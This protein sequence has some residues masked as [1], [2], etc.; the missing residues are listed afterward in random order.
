METQEAGN[1]KFEIPDKVT[2]SDLVE[3]YV[4]VT[5]KNNNPAVELRKLT[6]DLELVKKLVSAAYHERPIILLPRFSNKI[7]ALN[8]L[9]QK[10]I[11]FFDYDENIFYFTL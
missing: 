8:S 4:Q 11:I 6:T 7:Q 9:Q 10:G 2:I 3:I 1:P 5:E